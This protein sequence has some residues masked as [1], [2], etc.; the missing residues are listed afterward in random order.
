MYKAEILKDSITPLGYRLT[1]FLVTYPHAVHKDIMTHRWARNFQS[2]RAFPSERVIAMVE[3]D[4]FR[5]EVWGQRIRGMGEGDPHPNQEILNAYWDGHIRNCL[6][7]AKSLNQLGAA[8]AQINLALQDLSWI[9]GIITSCPEQLENFFELR[10]EVDHEGRPM[11]RPEV[12]RIAS[13]MHD[14]YQ[15]STP[16]LVV[17]GE[18]HLPFLTDDEY[19]ILPWGREYNKEWAIWKK[20]SAGR[21]G[22]V[23]YLT[24]DGKRDLVLDVELHDGL[25]SNGHMSP[26]EH[27]AT[28]QTE[29]KLGWSGPF[30]GW[31]QYRKQIPHESNYKLAKG[32]RDA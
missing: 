5:P 27:Q 13:M 16:G 22:R 17:P 26:F 23:S 18:W 28:P 31:D 6:M 4:P 29:P 19:A 11:A 20:V 30:Y 2:F 7:T 14:L 9:T 1:S 24:H 21:C 12:F 3:A 10:L 15:E 25:L 8:K 32:Y